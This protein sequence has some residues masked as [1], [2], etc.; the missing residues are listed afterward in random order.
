MLGLQLTT[1]KRQAKMAW[2]QTYKLARDILEVVPYGLGSPS[3]TLRERV[4]LYATP[5]SLSRHFF[6][7]N[8]KKLEDRAH[9]EC[10]IC[11]IRMEQ[12]IALLFYAERFHGTVSRVPA[13]RLVA[14]VL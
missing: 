12:K 11:N 4:A 10:R 6:K 1:R 5:G 9:N 14:Q 2:N 3:V 7:N 13:E 8:I